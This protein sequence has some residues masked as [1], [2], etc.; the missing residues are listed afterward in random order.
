MTKDQVKNT[1]GG[2]WPSNTCFFY[3]ESGRIILRR[4][5]GNEILAENY[6]ATLPNCSGV[7]CGY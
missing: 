6:C 4:V 5:F 3:N 1:T 2:A 7:S